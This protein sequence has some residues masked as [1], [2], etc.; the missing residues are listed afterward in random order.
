MR[1]CP[2]LAEF[3]SGNIEEILLTSGHN[4]QDAGICRAR[5]NALISRLKELMAAEEEV[6]Q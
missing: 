6:V 1:E 2:E 5:H 3:S 4:A